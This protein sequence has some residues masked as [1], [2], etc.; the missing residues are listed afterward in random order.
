MFVCIKEDIVGVFDWDFVVRNIFEVLINYLGLYVVW[1]YCVSYK[2]WKMELKWLVRILLMFSCWLMG[3]E[4]YLGVIIGKWFFIDYG[5]GVVIGEMVEI[6]DDVIL[7]YGVMFG[8]IS[9]KVGKCYLIL[10]NNVVVGV[11]VKVFGLIEIGE[12]VKI[13]LNFV[14]VKD[15][16]VGVMVVGILGWIV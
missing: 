7:Y 11:G 10:C 13:G 3:I 15:M 9:W 12:G 16:L 1:F 6:G 14:V 5:M 8:G 4:I 2:F